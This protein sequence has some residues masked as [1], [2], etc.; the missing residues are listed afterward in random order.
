MALATQCPHCHTTFRVAHDQLKLRAGL[1][2]CGAC[3]QI[4]NGIEHLLRPDQVN[5]APAQAP[6]TP[7]TPIPK[8]QEHHIPPAQQVTSTAPLPSNP[9][10]DFVPIDEQHAI[11]EH[12]QSPATAK[13]ADHAVSAAEPNDPLTRMTLMN[14]TRIEDEQE[15]ENDE[16]ERQSLIASQ[17]ADRSTETATEAADTVAEQPDPLDQAIEDLKQKP[18]RSENTS[19][20]HDPADDLIAAESDEPAFVIQG[21]KRQRRNR[22]LRISLWIASFALLISLLGQSIHLFRNQ[23]AAWFPQAKPALATAC[24]YLDCQVNL[25]SQIDAVSIESSELQALVPQKNTFALTILLRNYSST[26]EAWPHIE[27][28]LNDTNEKALVRKVFTPRDYLPAKQDLAKGFAA[29]SEQPVK[30]PFELLQLKASSYR[31][32]LF[33]P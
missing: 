21:R 4:F 8:A 2:R 9:S 15:D 16:A 1:V 13:T 28:T 12:T 30:I 17:T 20:P 18:W 27:L 29:N 26:A 14:F 24:Q 11:A 31:V 33:Y 32:Y 6:A 10:I 3:K 23:L 25:P 22:M 7:I 5:S 19:Q